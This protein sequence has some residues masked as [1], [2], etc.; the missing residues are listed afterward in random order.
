MLGFGWYQWNSQGPDNPSA[1]D[2][3]RVIVYRDVPL[4]YAQRLYP[5][6]R[7]RQDYRYVKYEDALAYCDRLLREYGEFMEQLKRTRDM[8][9]DRLDSRG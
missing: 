3:V 7:G 2:D 6:I 4:D 8:I 9:H 5:V 1:R